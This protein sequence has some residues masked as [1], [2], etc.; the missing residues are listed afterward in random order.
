MF[1]W[2]GRRFLAIATGRP[3]P[4]GG[5]GSQLTA[6][7][8]P[9]TEQLKPRNL[10]MTQFEAGRRG[11]ITEE[12]AFAAIREDLDPE[13]IRNEVARGRMVIPANVHHRKKGLEPM[14]IGIAAR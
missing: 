10:H 9:P 1:W 8:R 4:C 6:S 7:Q 13:L 14:C 3:R 2:P 5:C 12:M 11:I